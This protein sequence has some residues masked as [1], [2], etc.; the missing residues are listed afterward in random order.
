MKKIPK[1]STS[2]F[3]FLCCSALAEIPDDFVDVATV[4]K[5]VWVEAKY[6]TTDNFV[7]SQVDGYFL[8]KCI[9]HIEAAKALKKVAQELK[10]DDLG[11]KIF[12]CFRPQRA[13]DH[14]VRWAKNIDDVKTKSEFY[15]S[16]PKTELFAQGYIAEKS[17]HSRGATV[18]LTIYSLTDNSE[19]DM[20]SSYDFFDPIS[21]T[22]NNA[23][24]E[25]QQINRLKLKNMMARY[26]FKNYSKEWWHFTY[27]PEPYPDHYFD[28]EIK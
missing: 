11:L 5:S 4:T 3:C 19:M 26:G 28:G 25:Q 22:I 1:L 10:R 6:A 15:P 18:D 7:G 23:I 24:S 9:L 12:D 20:G 17:G 13:V 14:F 27:Q 16:V 8:N 21:H 2:L